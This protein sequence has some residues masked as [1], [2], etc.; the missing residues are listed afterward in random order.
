MLK[1]AANVIAPSLTYIFSLSLQSCIYVNDWK[2][3]NLK[4]VND[5]KCSNL[6]IKANVKIIDPSLF[7]QCAAWQCLDIITAQLVFKLPKIEYRNTWLWAKKGLQLRGALARA[8]YRRPVWPL[9][10]KKCPQFYWLPTSLT[11]WQPVNYKIVLQKLSTGT[12]VGVQK[13]SEEWTYCLF[14]IL[15]QGNSWS[16]Q[17]NGKSYYRGNDNKKKEESKRRNWE[18]RKRQRK[19]K[20]GKWPKWR[21]VSHLCQKDGEGQDCGWGAFLV[22]YSYHCYLRARIFISETQWLPEVK[23][24]ATGLVLSW[25]MTDLRCSPNLILNDLLVSPI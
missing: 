19:K 14:L 22:V 16:K 15:W 18:R 2:R 1:L 5:W 10:I 4:I 8:Q 17:R 25:L 13:T 21:K 20:G 11:Y 24:L 3:S 12:F 23:C 7:N 6:K 9:S